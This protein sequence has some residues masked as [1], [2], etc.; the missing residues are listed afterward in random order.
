MTWPQVVD[1]AL[2]V[3]LVLGIVACIAWAVTR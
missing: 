2:Q 3:I 1:H